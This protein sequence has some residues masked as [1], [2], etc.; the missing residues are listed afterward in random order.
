MGT[1]SQ[2]FFLHFRGCWGSGRRGTEGAELGEHE[3]GRSW[4]L[5]APSSALKSPRR[6]FGEGSLGGFVPPKGL[7]SW[8]LRAN[9][10]GSCWIRKSGCLGA[11]CGFLLGCDRGAGAHLE[12]GHAKMRRNPPSPRDVAEI[13][14]CCGRIQLP[15]WEVASGEGS[16]MSWPRLRWLQVPLAIP[17]ARPREHPGARLH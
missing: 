15:S 13:S 6:C 7:G 14:E 16:S 2:E 3:A 12:A 5:A 1:R 11:E 9:V 10:R 4:Q 8:Q 17:T